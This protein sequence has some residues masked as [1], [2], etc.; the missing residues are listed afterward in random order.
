MMKNL[1]TINKVSVSEPV[2]VLLQDYE[3]GQIKRLLVPGGRTQT[4]N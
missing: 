2:F 3:A 4:R 1:A